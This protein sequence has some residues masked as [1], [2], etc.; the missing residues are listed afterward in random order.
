MFETRKIGGVKQASLE[1]AAQNDCMA[2]LE[3]RAIELE[4]H[5][6]ISSPL[7]CVAES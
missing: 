3:A 4:K 5:L 7:V 2:E 1:L 6:K